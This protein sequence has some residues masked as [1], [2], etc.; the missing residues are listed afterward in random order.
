MPTEF[1]RLADLLEKAG[2]KHGA[3]RTRA[4]AEELIDSGDAPYDLG[5]TVERYSDDRYPSRST[6]EHAQHL[7][8]DPHE[9]KT[10]KDLAPLR[11]EFEAYDPTKVDVFDPEKKITVLSP[12][13]AYDL[14]ERIGGHA[15]DETYLSEIANVVGLTPQ[16]RQELRTTFSF[17][18][19]IRGERRGI[20]TVGELRTAKSF[21]LLERKGISPRRAVFLQTALK[22]FDKPKK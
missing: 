16:E 6:M 3:R 11:K 21:D 19:Y 15:S 20:N 14:R 12:K 9:A 18:E 8:F 17:L 7:L 22:R 4:F 5:D 10:E 2:F 13:F 1:E